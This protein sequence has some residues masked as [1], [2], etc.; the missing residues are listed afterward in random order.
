MDDCIFCMITV[1]KSPAHIVYEDDRFLSLL[2]TRPL[3]RGNS[4]VIPKKHVRWVDDVEEF[5]DYF[6]VAKRVGKA[7]QRAF[8]SL[9]TQYFTIG[10]EVE[11]AHIRVLPRYTDDQHGPLPDL[12]DV[13]VCS[14]E[15]MNHI[16][17]RLREEMMRL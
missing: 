5:G 13:Q 16:A 2:D 8:A 17:Q 14:E 1:K 15:E 9:W 4:L 6:E 7:A 3:T 10:H 11:H 12:S